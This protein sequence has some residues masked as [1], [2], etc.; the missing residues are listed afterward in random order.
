MDESKRKTTQTKIETRKEVL[1]RTFS[2]DVS[3]RDEGVQRLRQRW[4]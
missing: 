3:P 4:R 2:V 1:V